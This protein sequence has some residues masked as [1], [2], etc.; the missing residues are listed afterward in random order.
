[1][2]LNQQSARAQLERQLETGGIAIRMT[3]IAYMLAAEIDKL[4]EELDKI[5]SN[6]ARMAS[7]HG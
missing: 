3:S 6:D 1:M 5:K 7:P 4:R 2:K